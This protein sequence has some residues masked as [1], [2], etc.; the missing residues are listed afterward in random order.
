MNNSPF[1]TAQ[2]ATGTAA[3]TNPTADQPSTLNSFLFQNYSALTD[4]C[5]LAH[6]GGLLAFD[7]DRIMES[8]AASL[9]RFG[10]PTDDESA[11]LKWAERFVAHEATRIEIHGRLMAEHDR[12]LR[13]A[14]HECR[15]TSAADDAVS[16]EDILAEV[17]W[18]I[19]TK[20][21]S[22]DKRSTARTSTRLYGFVRKHCYLFHNAKNTRR[23]KAVRRHLDAGGHLQCEHLSSD[24]LAAMRDA[25]RQDA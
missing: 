2:T 4:S 21:H 23:L 9:H 5:Y 25:E 11:F 12:L 24:E 14:I 13:A 8:L 17:S 18:L 16:D 7:A 10:G 20:A 3:Q 22:L 15:W 1:D 19:W 6:P